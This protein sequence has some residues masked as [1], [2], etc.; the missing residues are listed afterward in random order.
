LRTI[1]LSFFVLANL[2]P[3]LSAQEE[4]LSLEI[5][6]SSS[7]NYTD[8]FILGLVEGVTEYLPVSSTGHLIIANHFLHLDAEV[9]FIDPE[10]QTYVLRDPENPD[11]KYTLKEAADAYAIVIQGGAILAVCFLYWKEILGMG[12]GILGMNPSG[13]KLAINLIIAFLPAAVLGPILDPWIESKLFH[14]WAVI[15][16]LIAGAFLMLGVNRWYVRK[17]HPYEGHAVSSPRMEDLTWKQSLFIGFL[18]CFAMWPGTS[19]SMMTIIGGFAVGL[20]PKRAAEFSFLLGLITLTAASSYKA[21]FEGPM[22][23]KV[24]DAGPLLFGCFIAFVS[25]AIAIKWFIQYLNKHG[26][27]LFAWYR[28]ALA[29]VVFVLVYV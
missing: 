7:F 19:R 6:P 11:S 20:S 21:L 4:K 23:L 17:K 28:I 9:P 26:L 10:T 16:A 3:T 27:G 22:M 8:A 18:Q 25:A 15:V 14:P 13:R 2:L 24:L 1:A 12:L 5:A 29:C